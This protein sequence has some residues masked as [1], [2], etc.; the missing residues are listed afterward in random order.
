MFE[1]ERVDN[2]DNLLT[3]MMLDKGGNK[4]AVNFHE[5]IKATERSFHINYIAPI[6]KCK[7]E[8]ERKN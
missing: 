1:F 8:N 5:L 7:F 4:Y 2:S 3:L 6:L